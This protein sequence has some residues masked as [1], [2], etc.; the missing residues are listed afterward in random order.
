MNDPLTIDFV[1]FPAVKVQIL[2]ELCE[3]G[4]HRLLQDQWQVTCRPLT[5][6][7]RLS[8]LN[9]IINLRQTV[10][11][12][13]ALFVCDREE[14]EEEEALFVRFLYFFVRIASRTL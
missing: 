3:S 4:G 9:P 13:L 1:L 2:C 5:S 10:L 12:P 6:S 14:E 8:K 11:W 7:T